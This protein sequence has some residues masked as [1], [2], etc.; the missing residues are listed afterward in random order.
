MSTSSGSR[1]DTRSAGW[2]EWTAC[3]Q[4]V[5]A[6][7]GSLDSTARSMSPGSFPFDQDQVG[8]AA[9]Q[10]L[11]AQNHRCRCP[12]PLGQPARPGPCQDPLGDHG[13]RRRVLWLTSRPRYWRIWT[14]CGPARVEGCRRASLASARKLNR[15]NRLLRLNLPTLTPSSLT[16]GRCCWPHPMDSC[17]GCLGCSQR[18]VD[19]SS[20]PGCYP[21][22]GSCVADPCWRTRRFQRASRIPLAAQ[23]RSTAVRWR[24]PAPFQHHSPAVPAWDGPGRLLASA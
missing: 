2:S 17:R 10:V 18:S 21:R 5:T 12:H 16:T 15:E 9:D 11:A 24:P 1:P 22:R 8:V 14:F 23:P 13:L 6:P 20:G 19:R 3:C 4:V 7:M